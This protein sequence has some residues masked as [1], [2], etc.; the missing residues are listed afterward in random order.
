[1]DRTH[2]LGQPVKRL[3]LFLLLGVLALPASAEVVILPST[4]DV[5]P[6]DMTPGPE[7]TEP[8]ERIAPPPA[9]SAKARWWRFF[10]PQ[11]TDAATFKAENKTIHVAGVEPPPVDAA[12]PLAGAESWPC[13]R[14]ALYSLRRFLH[15]RAVE[16][17]FPESSDLADVT[18]PCRVAT[19]DIGLW[20]LT[21]GWARPNDLATDDYR[22]AATDA[23]CAERGIWRGQTPPA[24]CP[25]PAKTN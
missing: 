1:M 6:S 14:T 10:L 20:L 2:H 22:S 25:A 16:C 15:G 13:G 19:N 3:C 11:T 9:P 12:C 23:L 24:D 8:L 5:T 7:V 4:R 21:E 17:F 18:A